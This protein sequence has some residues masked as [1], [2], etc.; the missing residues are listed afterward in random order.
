MYTSARLTMRRVVI[1][2]DSLKIR[3]SS[4]ALSLG[5]KK[6]TSENLVIKTSNR[7]QRIRPRETKKSPKPPAQRGRIIEVSITC[8]MR[9]LQSPR[10]MRTLA[11]K[12]PPRSRRDGTRE[13]GAPE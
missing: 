3:G 12:Y 2:P 5:E 8:T 7:S 4:V 11:I 13:S 9:L 6:S 1:R 10:K